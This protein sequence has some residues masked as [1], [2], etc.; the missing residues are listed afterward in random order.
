M[1]TITVYMGSTFQYQRLDE[2]DAIKLTCLESSPTLTDAIQCAVLHTT[3][4]DCDVDMTDH[5][6]ALSYVWGN[7]LGTV[8]ISVDW[9][10]SCGHSQSAFGLTPHAR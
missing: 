6:T 3:L 10:K 7:P 1:I 4:S 9:G 5:Y 2:P 8:T